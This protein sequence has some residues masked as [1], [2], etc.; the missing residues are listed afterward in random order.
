[1]AFSLFS[2]VLLSLFFFTFKVN[3]TTFTF[4]NKC[5][6]TVWPASLSNSGTAPL[7][8]T[9]FVLPSG[10]SLAIQAPTGW[11]GRFWARTSC[12][13]LPP[14]NHLTCATGDC[15]SGQ[16]ECSGA[17]ASPPATL[18]EFT[19]AGPSSTKDF[20]DVS[21]VDGYN[22]PMMVVAANGGCEA[23][24]CAVDLNNRCP[25]EL[26]VG[27]GEGEGC[28]SACE[29]FGKEEYCCSGEYANPS[30]CKPTVYSEMFKAA[31]PRSYSYA[32]DDPTSTFTCDGPADY[33]II[34]CPNADPSSSSSSYDDPSSSPSQ[35][36][37]RDGT[38]EPTT[39]GVVLEGG[40]SWLAN[41]AM[42]DA[43]SSRRNFSIFHQFS[44]FL[45]LIFFLF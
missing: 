45:F 26:R 12:T 2:S 42:G 39:K 20:Y 8:T 33:T 25:A 23:T 44:L 15:G 14:S 3:S 7:S 40:E 1:M 18:A 30:V 32:F 9:G 43:P 28:R 31:C 29:A 4:T 38:T 27:E 22:I 37:S 19:L 34:F 11:S 35:K 17:G 16:I 36:S 6:N 5:A 24:G 10:A 13:T 21:L 41:L